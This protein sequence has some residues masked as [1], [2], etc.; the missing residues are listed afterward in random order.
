MLYMWELGTFIAVADSGSFAKGAE[1]RNCS[2]VSAMN[3]INAVELQVGAKLFERTNR[4]VTLT[5]AGKSVYYDAKKIIAFSDEA[6]N[7]A[8]EIAGQEK[9]TIRVGT[10]ILRPC[11][12]LVDLWQKLQK[13]DENREPYRLEIVQF[14]DDKASM[15]KMLDTLGKEIDCFISPCDSISWKK[16]FEI[17][18][19]GFY[20]CLIAVPKSN[21]LSKK[22]CLTWRDL[23][24]QT[25]FLVKRGESSILDKMRDEIVR[26]HK[27]ITVQDLPSLYD[28]ASFNKCA[29]K[30]FLMETLE[31]WADIHPELVTL[32]M[33]WDY[34][35]P[36]GIV[37]SKNASKTVRD[38]VEKF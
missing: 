8:K 16:Q 27:Q 12:P 11:K 17:L 18:Q 30:G 6:E 9:Y 29:Q 35:M 25:I 33:N 26:E 31:P 36:Y 1:K 22:N 4:G 32:P 14:G 5:E 13:E 7:R 3:Q 37:Y 2:T 24:G 23:D 20:R 28:T 38:F 19:L 10:S 21:L 15:K 34:K